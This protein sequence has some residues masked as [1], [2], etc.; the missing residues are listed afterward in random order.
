MEP[1]AT[2]NSD[3]NTAV[4]PAYPN[5]RPWPKGVSG[6]VKG[7]PP[8]IVRI[9]RE[10][11]R[12][13]EDIADFHL[14]IMHGT[15]PP[16]LNGD[17]EVVQPDRPGEASIT[18]RQ[19]SADW[20]ADRLLGRADANQNVVEAVRAMVAEMVS[21]LDDEPVPEDIALRLKE[22]WREIIGRY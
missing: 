19:R 14:S 3:E 20:I 2:K 21:A 4:I 5:L 15:V 10:K 7:R 13:G 6:N 1:E 8:S 16:V 9:L 17:G 18:E 12:D 22:R 11:T